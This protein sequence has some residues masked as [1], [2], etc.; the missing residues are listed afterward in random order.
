MNWPFVRTRF[1]R[2]RHHFNLLEINGHEINYEIRSAEVLDLFIIFLYKILDNHTVPNLKQIFISRSDMQKKNAL[3][4][5]ISRAAGSHRILVNIVIIVHLTIYTHKN[6]KLQVC[7]QVVTNLFT[8]CRQVVF[9]LLVPIFCDELLTTCNKFDGI[10]RLVTRLFS[11]V[12]YDKESS[13]STSTL[14]VWVSF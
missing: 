12:W 1:S 3:S 11:Q 6:A 14:W 4:Y 13:D 9:A 8:S 2:N 10:I 7:K 5:G